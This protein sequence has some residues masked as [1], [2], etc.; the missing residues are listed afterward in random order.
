MAKSKKKSTQNVENIGGRVI[1]AGGNVTVNEKSSKTVGEKIAIWVGIAAAVVAIITGIVKLQESISPSI[2]ES[3]IFLGRVIDQNN[4]GVEAATVYTLRTLHGDTLG[5]G[6]T[7]ARGEFNFIV[8][9][10]P[11]N[12]VYI[13]IEKDGVTHQ[14]GFE[15]LGSNKKLTLSGISVRAEKN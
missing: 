5:F 13:L 11:E 8:Q 10:K 15:V 12:S 2:P 9:S 4:Q 14:H 7:D 3:S 1:Q 6:Q